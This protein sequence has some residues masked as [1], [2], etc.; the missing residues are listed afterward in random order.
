M[1]K[2]AL[3][4]LLGAIDSIDSLIASRLL[5]LFTVFIVIQLTLIF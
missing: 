5:V 4:A 3:D 2:Y 1:Y